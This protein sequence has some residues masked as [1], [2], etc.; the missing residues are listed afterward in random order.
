MGMTTKEE[1][2]RRIQAA[3]LAKDMRLEDV[4]TLVPEFSISRLSNWEQ[5]RNMIGVDEAKKLGPALGVR[6]GYL[7]T[8]DD[9]P[10]DPREK[11]LF[12]YYHRCDE[13]GRNQ[14]LRVAEAESHY[15]REPNGDAKAA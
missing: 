13:R 9:E 14:I 12:E 8:L 15:A 7:L 6:P 11:A 1:A 5:G 3:R 4:Q 2:G 10:I